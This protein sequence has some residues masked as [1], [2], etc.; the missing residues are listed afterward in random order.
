MDRVV[1]LRDL[2][3]GN[4]FE[5]CSEVRCLF[6]TASFFYATVNL[7]VARMLGENLSINQ[8]NKERLLEIFSIE[9]IFSAVN[10]IG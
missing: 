5:I 1:K 4:G 3:A 6:E 10:G 7:N 2:V 9:G 8:D